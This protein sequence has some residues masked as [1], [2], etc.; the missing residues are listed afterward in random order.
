MKQHSQDKT[1]FMATAAIMSIFLLAMGV[2]TITPAIQNIAEA[3]PNVP[4]TTIIYVSTLPTLTLLPASLI[5]GAVAGKK[6]KYKTLALIGVLLFIISGCA[7]AFMNSTFTLVLISRAVL[8]IALGIIAPLGNAIIFGL[9]EGQKRANLVGI[10]T[11]VTNLGGV[12][13]Q[14]LGGTLAGINWSYCFLGHALGIISFLIILFFLPEPKKIE[15][16]SVDTKSG[17]K[18]K[19]GA[20][21]WIICILFGVINILNYPTMMNMSTLLVNRGLGDATV[22]AT[23]LSL[24]TVGGMIGGAIFGKVFQVTKRF[25]IAVACT[26]MAMGVGLI[27]IAKS[28]FVM[29]AGTTLL[30]LGFSICM[31]AIFMILGIMTTPS[32]N[33]FAISLATAIMNFGGF[34][35]TY[36]VMAIQ[37]ITG[38]GVFMPIVLEFIIFAIAALVFLVV[39]PMPKKKEVEEGK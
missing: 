18:E 27:V 3:Y 26:I 15:E 8:G 5:T 7:P 31:P 30:G 13:L 38:D 29:M 20:G 11:V 39:N 22:A 35:S 2:G 21:V 17:K 12:V 6:V 25:V 1:G 23:V 37:G 4:Y 34:V 28:T 14:M 16:P 24:F 33:T 10:G 19:L 9:Y 36:W 32:Q